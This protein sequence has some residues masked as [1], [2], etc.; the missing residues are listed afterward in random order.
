MLTAKDYKWMKFCMAG[1]ELFSTCAKKQ[2]FAFILDAHG[3]VVAT[4]WNGSAPGQLHCIDGGCPRARN[5][6]PSG[7]IYDDCVACH[8]EQ[9]ALIRSRTSNYDGCTLYVNGPPCFTCA[10]LIASAGISRVVHLADDSY[11]D[12][13]RVRGYLEDCGVRVLQVD[14]V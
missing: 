9:N 10:K 8:S 7:S 5:D 1:A 4:G 13:P 11:A 12:W 3:Y 2:Y 6:S 14:D